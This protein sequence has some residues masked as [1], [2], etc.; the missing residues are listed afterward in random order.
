MWKDKILLTSIVILYQS[1]PALLKET[2]SNIE[3]I[4][5]N[6]KYEI[7]IIEFKPNLIKPEYDSYNYI[8]YD[9]QEITKKILENTT[10]N[11]ITIVPGDNSYYLK[12]LPTMIDYLTFGYNIVIGTKFLNS[13]KD[14]PIFNKYVCNP[15]KRIIGKHFLNI[16]CTDW[17][18]EFI[19]FKKDVLVKNE[20]IATDIE[21]IEELLIKSN[22]SMIKIGEIPVNYYP[23]PFSKDLYSY[24]LSE[25]RRIRFMTLFIPNRIIMIPSI[26]AF[27][28]S[29]II[30]VSLLINYNSNV[31]YLI[32]TFLF[33]LIS[34]QSIYT[35]KTI[36]IFSEKF[37]QK[38]NKNYAIPERI[39]LLGGILLICSILGLVTLCTQISPNETETTYFIYLLLPIIFTFSSGILSILNGYTMSLLYTKT[40]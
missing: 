31:V 14:I 6:K 21:W 18:T 30:F 26:S 12:E 36:S 8:N 27:T 32:V 3:I 2:I 29:F 7:I 17:N 35:S 5:L 37:K 9:N 24:W 25:W 15:I 4:L 11:T 40:K 13:N 28:F 19:V 34:L 10:S 39:I 20:I 22:R 16:N 23:V 1:T 38:T 33:S